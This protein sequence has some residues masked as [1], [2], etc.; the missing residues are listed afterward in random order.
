MKDSDSKR[1]TLMR[2]W[3]SVS[4]WIQHQPLTDIKEYFGAHIALYFAW[5]GFYTH[6]LIPA[7]IFGIICLL[8]GL[9]KMFTSPLR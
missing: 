4:K 6:M 7:S 1:D 9:A 3:A 8:F 2:D 5:L